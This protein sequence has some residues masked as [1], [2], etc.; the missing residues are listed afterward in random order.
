MMRCR[1][2]N[3]RVC[4]RAVVSTKDNL[5]QKHRA[6]ERHELMRPDPYGATSDDNADDAI[7]RED[8]DYLELDEPIA[9]VRGSDPLDPHQTTSLRRDSLEGQ[10]LTQA[11]C[12]ESE[13]GR[14]ACDDVRDGET[15][16]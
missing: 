9:A 10:Y 5:C 1:G 6:Q 16:N 15:I 7:N 11:L 2:A 14:N 12:S 8:G 4:Y 3:G 13:D